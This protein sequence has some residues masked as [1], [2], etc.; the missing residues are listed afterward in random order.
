M[1]G[2]VRVLIAFLLPLA[3][4]GAERFQGLARILSPLLR[5][6]GG[7]HPPDMLFFPFHHLTRD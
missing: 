3:A 1:K 5:R 2:V 6:P 4:D 7:N